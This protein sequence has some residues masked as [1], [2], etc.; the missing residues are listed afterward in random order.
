MGEPGTCPYG[1]LT[2]MPR[3]VRY[4][5]RAVIALFDLRVTSKKYEQWFW[6]NEIE[7]EKAIAAP[8]LSDIQV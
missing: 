3:E 6:K 5:I 1:P 8:K 7:R 4:G 2:P